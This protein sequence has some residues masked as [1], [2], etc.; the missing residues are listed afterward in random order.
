M[1][2]PSPVSLCPDIISQFTARPLNNMV[3]LGGHGRIISKFFHL[4]VSVIVLVLL[5]SFVGSWFGISFGFGLKKAVSVRGS[6]RGGDK[7]IRRQGAVD[8]VKVGEQSMA[9]GMLYLLSSAGC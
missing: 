6:L 7:A 1:C 8:W 9:E 5:A 4:L 3:L 2:S